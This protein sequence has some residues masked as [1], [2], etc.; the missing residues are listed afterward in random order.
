MSVSFRFIH[1]ADLHVDSP[2]KGLS[3]APPYVQKALLEATFD[4]V[5]NL[6]QAAIRDEVDFV[7]HC[8]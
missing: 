5:R 3:E 4:A 7:G 6:V 8:R 1:A 2:F